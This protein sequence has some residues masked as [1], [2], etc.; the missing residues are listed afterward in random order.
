MKKSKAFLIIFIVAVLFIVSLPAALV[1]YVDP[2]FHYHKPLDGKNY[3]LRD[4]R[5]L[6][7]GIVKNFD[8]DA[9][10][11]GSS[12][13]ECFRPSVMDSLW[14]T[15]GIKVPFSGGSF[16]EVGDLTR[17]ACEANP[18]LKMVIRGI[19][20]NRFFNTK[21]ERDY[22]ADSYPTYLYDNNILNDTKYVFSKNAIVEAALI[23][24]QRGEASHYSSFDTYSNWS[25][26][27]RFG[28]DEVLKSYSREAVTPAESQLPL[29]DEEKQ[30]MYENITANITDIADEYPNVEFYLYY[31]PY[32][33]YYIDYYKRLGEL[34]KQIE[35]E[36]YITSLLLE[37]ENIHVYS[38][39]MQHELIE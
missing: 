21:D 6:N 15:T 33:I 14:G 27:Y 1:V 31:T 3:I 37:H 20:C 12:M 13:T 24:I 4:Q 30:I 22:D 5:Y 35:A 34:D 18:D 9:M 8:Y 26:D 16:L 29:T 36:K 28:K 17:T 2:Y 10:I 25:G 32:S 11:T 23:L 19:D 7:D 38:F 39:Y